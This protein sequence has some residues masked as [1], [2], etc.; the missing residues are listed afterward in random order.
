MSEQTNFWKRIFG[1]QSEQ[2]EPEPDPFAELN[3]SLEEIRQEVRKLGKAQYKANTLVEGQATRWQATA[4]Q[5]SVIQAENSQLVQKIAQ[6]TAGEN[7][8]VLLEA[9]LPAIDSV[10]QA[11][12]SGYGYLH[13]RDLQ[14]IE[15]ELFPTQYQPLANAQ[16]RD[17]LAGWLNGLRL[18]RERLLNLLAQDGVVRIAT[19]GEPFNPY[20]HVAVGT[21]PTDVPEEHNQIASEQKTGYQSAQG[22]F[23]YAEVTVKT[24]TVKKVNE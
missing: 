20:L 13:Q 24:E 6:Q 17:A 18:V 5:L 8:Q 15:Q 7:R 14:A 3:G 12:L 4:D 2:S 16:D 10:E 22:V 21:I 19:V 11:L 9:L 1:R 23:R